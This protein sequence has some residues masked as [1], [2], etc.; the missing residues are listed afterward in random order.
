[1]KQAL[2]RGKVTSIS[3]VVPP[4][5]WSD[6]M[7]CCK[8]DAGLGF[9]FFFSEVFQFYVI[10]STFISKPIFFME[11]SFVLPPNIS[12]FLGHHSPSLWGKSGGAH[13]GAYC[14]ETPG[15]DAGL[16]PAGLSKNGVSEGVSPWNVGGFIPFYEGV[17]C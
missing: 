7:R 12:E 4:T 15:S 2:L 1:M 16:I 17:Y 8:S 6:G 9:V 5:R 10:S 3:F 14:A 13:I 11:I